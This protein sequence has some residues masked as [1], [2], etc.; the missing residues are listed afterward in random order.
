MEGL[1]IDPMAPAGEPTQ[2]TLARYRGTWAPRAHIRQAA[3]ANPD[4]VGTTFVE[5]FPIGGWTLKAVRK[6]VNG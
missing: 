6:L 1:V 2:E 3:L 4:D 5:Y